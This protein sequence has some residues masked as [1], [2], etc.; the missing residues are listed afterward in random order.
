LSE[1]Y[2][3]H[4]IHFSK[5][6][7]KTI[8]EFTFEINRKIGHGSKQTMAIFMNIVLLQKPLRPQEIELLLKEFSQYL[9]LSHPSSDQKHLTDD[10]WSRVEILF[11][12]SLTSEELAKA[13]QLHWIHCPTAQ[14][15]KLCLDLIAKQGKILITDTP[16]ENIFQV[17]EFVMSGILAFAKHLFH[18]REMSQFPN[19]VWDSKWR[20]SVWT[21][22]NRVLLQIGLGKMGTEIARR[23]QEMGMQVWGAQ[24]HQTFHPYCLK[25]FAMHEVR[26]IL[27]EADVVSLSLPRGKEWENWF[28]AEELNLMKNDSILVL[29][30]S[31]RVI[32]IE[33]LE[34]V[35]QSGKFR[36][37]LMDIIYH[38]PIPS[39]SPLWK[40]PNI[41]ITPDIAPQPK[42]IATQAFRNFLY[43]LR[44]YMHSNFKDM[45]NIVKI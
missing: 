1:G 4:K 32:N 8:A 19:L 15:N 14:L 36:G 33:A 18:W 7:D 41:V 5:S 37:I 30:G 25:T 9:F 6:E 16:E 35:A 17:G 3:L 40:I 23:A 27:S 21:L 38:Q 20:R 29:R 11:G 2:W 22:Q 10:Y 13:Q 43:N 44:Q 12:N 31:H 24:R 34:Q 26:N 45:R 42:N 28:R 39:S